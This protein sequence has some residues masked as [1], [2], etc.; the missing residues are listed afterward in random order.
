MIG[1][2]GRVCLFFVLTFPVTG[3][4]QGVF[5]EISGNGLSKPS[6]LMGTVHLLCE[7]ELQ[8]GGVLTEKLAG[9][10]ALILEV[11]LDDPNLAISMMSKM[12]NE[13]GESITDY[14]SDGE[15]KEIRNLL[16]ERTGVDIGMLKK[17]RPF[18]L[19]SLIY[20]SLLECETKSYESELMKLAKSTKAEIHGLESVDDQLSVFDQIPLDEQYRSFYEYA[21]DLDKGRVEF[22][23]LIKAYR[24]EDIELLVKMVSESPEY[25]DYQDILL[26][27][28]NLNWIEP[29]GKWMREG[30]V[31]FAVGAGHLGGENGLIQLLK[32]EGYRLKRIERK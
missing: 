22:Q 13:G 3:Q 21:M 11:D 16:M 17:L 4:D 25:R 26:D 19:M 12:H 30:P 10:K 24:D 23:R 1:A 15:Y 2:I 27:N 7:D 9:S 6:Y 31:F 20:P 5:W 14:L 29:M 32:N 18:M 28:R 8:L